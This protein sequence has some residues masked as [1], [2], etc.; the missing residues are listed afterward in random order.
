MY[1]LLKN[2]IKLACSLLDCQRN[3]SKEENALQYASL[4]LLSLPFNF[5]FYK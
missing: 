4:N 5:T 2:K 1:Y 3:L